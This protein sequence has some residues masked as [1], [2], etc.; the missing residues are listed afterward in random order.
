MSS[1]ETTI[2]RLN[3]LL[4][5][6]LGRSASGQPIYS[7]A[8]SEDLFFL[9]PKLDENGDIVCAMRETEGGL[10]AVEAI[11]EPRKMCA[12]LDH[13]WVVVMWNQPGSEAAWKAQFGLKLAYPKNGYLAPTNMCLGKSE[14]PDAAVT[15]EVIGKI[16]AERKKT[17]HDYMAESQRD[18]DRQDKRDADN[19]LDSVSDA[20]TAF[21][22]VPGRKGGV[23]F[24]TP[25]FL[26]TP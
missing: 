15:E 10:T 7:W 24:P 12:A 26:V 2:K 9:G 11:M 19:L 25:R 16:R 23:S 14:I 3:D 1:L 21:G 5:R 6:E 13:Q 22:A 20:C 8:F 4:G 17:F 18:L